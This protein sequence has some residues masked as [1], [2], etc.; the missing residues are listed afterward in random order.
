MT[1]SIKKG[2]HVHPNSFQFFADDNSS[3]KQTISIYNPFD[4]TVKYK[5]LST[6]PKRYLVDVPEDFI[7]PK[8][9][10]ELVIRHHKSSF[11]ENTKDKLRIQIFNSQVTL[12]YKKDLP[13]DSIVSREEFMISTMRDSDYVSDIGNEYSTAFTHGNNLNSMMGMSTSTLPNAKA[14]L[15]DNRKNMA[16]YYG[17]SE[18]SVNYLVIFIGL[19]CLTLI[20]LPVIGS[21][22]SAIP[23]YMHMTYEA[24]MFASFVL[25]MVTMVILKS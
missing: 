15:L 24:K 13:L 14:K 20:F 7:E 9:V 21:S 11:D 10:V 8:T 22:N 19:I 5:V 2:V 16:M 3:H 25:G 18:A 4:Q 12:I 1:Q 17:N 23:V 6:A